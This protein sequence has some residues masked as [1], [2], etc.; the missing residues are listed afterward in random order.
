[1]R[2]DP[3]L[4]LAY[5]GLMAVLVLLFLAAFVLAALD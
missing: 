4:R 1:M 2:Y 3:K 5:Y